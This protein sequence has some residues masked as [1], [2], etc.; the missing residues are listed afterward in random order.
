MC[1][2]TDKFE[3]A[4]ETP[5]YWR[6]SST[7]LRGAA[8]AVW[9]AMDSG[10]E[11]D[12]AARC[13]LGEA[14]DL[15]VAGRPVYEMLC[16]ISLELLYKAIAVAK[17]QNILTNHR[18]VELSEYVGIE[19]DAREKGLLEILTEAIQWSGRY[20]IPKER[21]YWDK[22]AQLRTEHLYTKVPLGTQSVLRPNGELDWL[23]FNELWL[24]ADQLYWEHHYDS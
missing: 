1:Q 11:T 17:R 5:L 3:R 13:G 22:T 7:D 12:I 23:S 2:Y 14:F 16:G 15:R 4:S 10:R 6:N 20:P 24:K 8:A 19:P 18:L 9:S 21:K